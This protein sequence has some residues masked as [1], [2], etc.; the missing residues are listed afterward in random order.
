MHFIMA[1]PIQLRGSTLFYYISDKNRYGIKLKVKEKCLRSVFWQSHLV[2]QI[3]HGPGA[4]LS[5]LH[6]YPLC[7]LALTKTTD[8]LSEMCPR[9][10]TDFCLFLYHRSY[11]I[12][13]GPLIPLRLSLDVMT[14]ART[15]YP[16]M[17][18][19]AL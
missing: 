5:Q 2:D 11:T 12:L 18:E 9:K 3:F 1:F 19:P 6:I 16:Q 13:L 4:K 10:L 17:R 8:I 7:G 14:G 15:G